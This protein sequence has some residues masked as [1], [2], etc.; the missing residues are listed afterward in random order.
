MEI[1]N[2]MKVID[3]MDGNKNAEK[4]LDLKGDLSQK[5]KETLTDLKKLLY[6]ATIQD[7][8]SD[9]QS[10]LEAI[11]NPSAERGSIERARAFDRGNKKLI[12]GIISTKDKPKEREKFIKEFK[13]NYE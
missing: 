5:D 4:K 10:L 13:K 7:R 6:S 8:P 12:Y 11:K 1:K 3:N 2:G 9:N